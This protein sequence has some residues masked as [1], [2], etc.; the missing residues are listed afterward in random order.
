MDFCKPPQTASGLT[1]SSIHL[2]VMTG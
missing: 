1:T 2:W